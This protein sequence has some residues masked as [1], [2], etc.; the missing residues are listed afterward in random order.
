MKTYIFNFYLN[1]NQLLFYFLGKVS[2]N[3]FKF[4]EE[5]MQIKSEK[6]Q[7][8]TSM[9]WSKRFFDLNCQNFQIYGGHK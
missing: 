6:Y 9:I 8:K 3:E 4:L 1:L 2:I 5:N 7:Q